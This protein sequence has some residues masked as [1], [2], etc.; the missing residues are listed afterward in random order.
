MEDS[1]HNLREL[2]ETPEVEES[3]VRSDPLDFAE[4]GTYETSKQLELEADRLHMRSKY[5]L[6]NKAI[7]QKDARTDVH[8]LPDVKDHDRYG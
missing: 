2:Q 5:Y 4:G 1:C 3:A 8:S 7:T 6:R